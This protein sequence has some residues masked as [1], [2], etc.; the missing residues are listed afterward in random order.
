MS[1]LAPAHSI[2]QLSLEA[3]E[4]SILSLGTLPFPNLL[5]TVH[6]YFADQ[7]RPSSSGRTRC[8]T[9]WLPADG[10]TSLLA[11]PGAQVFNDD[12]V[13]V[14]TEKDGEHNVECTRTRLPE[15]MAPASSPSRVADLS[16][17]LRN[18]RQVLGERSRP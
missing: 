16:S 4:I 7:G 3:W 11:S 1:L 14:K 8:W 10:P 12:N 9:P 2:P 17:C 13:T 5:R 18:V 6:Q 15:L